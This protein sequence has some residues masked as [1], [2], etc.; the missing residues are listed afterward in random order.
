MR[1]RVITALVGLPLLL[2]IIWAGFRFYLITVLASLVA[3]AGVIEFCGLATRRGGRPLTL[4]AV[5]WALSF[6]VAAHLV[7]RDIS[8]Y[9]P[10][11]AIAAIGLITSL[12]WLAWRRRER[13]LMDWGYT[14]GAAFYVGWTL[15]HALLLRDLDQGF[16]WVY[17]AL[18][19]TFATDTGAFFV[20]RAVGRTPLA[21][22]ISPGKT[23]E[24]AAG[25]FILGL[26]ACT[27]LSSV[28]SLGM[29]VWQAVLLGA[30][31][32]AGGQL[33]DLVESALKRAAGVQESGVLVPG[34]GGILDR[35]DS[36]VFNLVV[37]YHF[38]RWVAT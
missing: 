31:I 21:P 36:I 13:V 11:L 17:L 33:G 1:L 25:G 30:L 6:L 34:H 7:T 16:Q 9:I 29:P 26:A 5:A 23:R 22:A 27:L 20:G 28:F 38:A 3:V 10:F 32:G 4:F 15:S 8:Y 37:V 35:L 18:L 24:G 19:S 14:L 2:L 12:G